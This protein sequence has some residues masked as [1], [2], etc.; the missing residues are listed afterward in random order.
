MGE[1]DDS[2]E[3]PAL[4]RF[5]A[6]ASGIKHV[7]G[8]AFRWAAKAAVIGGLVLGALA[9][10]PAG[11]AGAANAL[12]FGLASKVGFAAGGEWLMSGLITGLKFGAIGGAVLGAVSGLASAGDAVAEEKEQIMAAA[13]NAEL[14]ERRNALFKQQQQTMQYAGGVR[15]NVGF[16]QGQGVYNEGPTRG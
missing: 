11:L 6:V 10:A 4:S 1:Q 3:H 5:S 13:D 2:L 8:K 9:L 16:G 12:T 15:P 7:A 14:R